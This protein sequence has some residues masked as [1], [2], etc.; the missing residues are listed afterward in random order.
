MPKIVLFS[1]G[2]SGNHGCEAIVRATKKILDHKELLLVSAHPTEDHL[3]GI[4]NL[5]TVVQDREPRLNRFSLDFY[6]AYIALKLTKNFIPLEKLYYKRAF[7]AIEPGDIAMSIGGDNY[8]YADA[9]KYTMFHEIAKSRGAK[10]VLW[11]CSVE[12]EILKQPEFAKDISNYDLITARETIS[13][14]ALKRINPH[15]VLVSDPAFCLDSKYLP[16][17]DGFIEGNTVG[18]NI[19]PMIM[20]N[21]SI[22]GITLKNYHNLIQHILS[23]TDMYIALLNHVIW[24]DNDDR[25]PLRGLYDA[26]KDSGRVVMIEDHNC[27]ELKGYIA[28]C[29]FFIGARTHATIAAYSSC[30]PTLVVGYSV[31]AKGIAQDILGQP[32]KYVLSV[33]QFKSENDLKDAFIGLQNNEFDVKTQLHFIDYMERC[34]IGLQYVNNLIDCS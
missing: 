26:Y 34:Y 18:I 12:P 3:Y 9:Y 33:Q 24:K 28:R 1:H 20:Q 32:N 31:K 30:V 19:S 5:C 13:Y 17:P 8:C 27:E 10:T 21:E 4:D 16:L 14:N 25:I 6:T 29:S 2:G 23:Q 22:P 15:T 7:S 11:G